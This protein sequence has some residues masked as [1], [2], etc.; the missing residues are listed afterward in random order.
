MH[1]GDG[2][3]AAGTVTLDTLG[4]ETPLAR[5]TLA[6]PADFSQIVAPRRRNTHKGSYGNALVIGGGTGMV[7]AAL[8]RRGRH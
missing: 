3:D 7:G 6:D 8:S 1:T 5:T 4:I 2:V